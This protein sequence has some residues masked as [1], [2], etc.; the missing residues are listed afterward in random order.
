MTQRHSVRTLTSFLTCAALS[1]L[2]SDAAAQLIKAPV[3]S[4]LLLAPGEERSLTLRYR[5]PERV[6]QSD[7]YRL[8]WQ[9]QS[10]T[11]RLPVQVT[12]VG[13]DS[14]STSTMTGAWAS[15][16]ASDGALLLRGTLVTDATIAVMGH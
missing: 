11:R 2:T 3:E 1:I 4:E 6:W 16:P 8:L 10:G 5:L 15:E 7:T 9:K 13:A 12:L 14:G